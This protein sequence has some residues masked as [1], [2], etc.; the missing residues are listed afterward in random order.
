MKHQYQLAF[1]KYEN[2]YLALPAIKE[3]HCMFLS[4]ERLLALFVLQTLCSDSR[5][6]M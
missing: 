3:Y 1:F 6:F 2:S 4:K 5:N